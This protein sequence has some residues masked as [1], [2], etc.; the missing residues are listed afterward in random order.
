M[1]CGATRRAIACAFAPRGNVPKWPDHG[2]ASREACVDGPLLARSGGDFSGVAFACV[3][4]SGLLVQRGCWPRWF[5]R[6]EIQTIQRP[7]LAVA[8][9]GLSPVADR[10]IPSI[11]PSLARS[12]RPSLNVASNPPISSGDSVGRVAA[13]VALAAH[14]QL[15]GDPRHLVGE[16]HRRELGGLAFKQRLH[17]AGRVFRRAPA[18]LPDHRSRPDDEQAARIGSP[19]RVMRPG[20]A[21]PAVEW[22][23]GV[24]PSQAA[25]SRPVLKRCGSGVF[26]TRSEA[27][28]GPTPGIAARRRDV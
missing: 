4:V 27:V 7:R 19:A 6:R 13:R 1:S 18:D 5:P 14:H 10:T 23:R 11:S 26:I 24:S 22:S 15:P 16:R 2:P 21:L 12:A 17:P 20:R 3:H 25:K 8:S 9:R 28:S